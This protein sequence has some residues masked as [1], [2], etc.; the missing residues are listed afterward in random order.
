M[1]GLFSVFGHRLRAFRVRPLTLR[2]DEPTIQERSGLIVIPLR[3]N[4]APYTGS[5]HVN[6]IVI[7]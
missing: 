4:I 1:L 5:S 6:P 3:L 2:G 7:T